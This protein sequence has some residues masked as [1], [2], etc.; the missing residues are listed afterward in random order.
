MIK[1]PTIIITSLGRT[2]TKFFYSLFS[3]LISDGTSLHEPDVLNISQYHGTKKRLVEIV[4][5]ARESGVYNLFIR[6]AIGRWSL[7]ELSDAR[8]RGDISRP[9]TSKHVLKLREYFINS[10]PGS[11]YI[12]SSIALYGLIDILQYVCETHKVAYIVRDGRDWIKSWMSWSNGSGIYDKGRIRSLV[13]H[14]WPTAAECKGDSHAKKWQSMSRFGKLCWGWSRLNRYA[15]GTIQQNPNARVFRFED[16]FESEDRYQHL[17][18]LINFATDMPGVDPVPAEALDGWLDRRI[19]KS[20]GGFPA[21]SE[22]S[23]Q[24]KQQFIEICGPLMEE[25]G[26]ELN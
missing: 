4:K 18:E 1:K 21:W 2:G 9:E 5:Q 12:E 3:E 13:A 22:W 14:T 8:A 6:K 24:Q 7:I 23:T 25:L 15:L 17:A 10:R 16:I 19:H 26:Y 11:V 20:S